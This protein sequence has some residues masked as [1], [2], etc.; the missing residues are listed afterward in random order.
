MGNRMQSLVPT[1]VDESLATE[2]QETGGVK[3][4]Q[5]LS[6][7]ELEVCRAFYDWVLVNP[8]SVARRFNE[9]KEDSYYND[10]GQAKGYRPLV[11]ALFEACPS[12]LRTAQAL[13]G[14]ENQN[15]WFAGYEV[16]HK[17]GGA[18]RNTPFHQDA[19]F[20]P[21]S[22][23]HIVRFWIPFEP[24]KK[25]YCLQVVSGSHRGPLF[26]PNK[27]FF[28]DPSSPDASNISDTTPMFDSEDELRAM[29]PLPDI[30]ASPE[31]HD[32]LSWNL[33]PG[34]AVAF[35]LAALHGNAPVDTRHPE[36]NTLI[37]GFMGDDCIY[38]PL[39]IEGSAFFADPQ[40]YTGL[41]EGDHFSLTGATESI[42][43]QGTGP[44]FSA[45]DVHEN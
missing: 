23:K 13:F 10:V 27:V 36:R 25:E 32:I 33:D 21:F 1:I 3:V 45:K 31:E 30:L 24:T 29:P 12:L 42:R 43:L 7:A 40:A 6:P 16:F 26:N 44:I 15:I 20:A 11:E 34:D 41:E 22:G 17:Y 19:A 9:G 28:I 37:L 14:P 2:W 4:S 8:S 38:K 5:L 35:H 18:G 39:P